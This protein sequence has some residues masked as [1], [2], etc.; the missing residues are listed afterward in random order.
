MGSLGPKGPSGEKGTAGPAGPPGNPG[1]KGQP[2]PKVSVHNYVF[3]FQDYIKVFEGS[4][5]CVFFDKGQAGLPGNRG[6]KGI[7]G[8]PVSPFFCFSSFVMHVNSNNS[9]NNK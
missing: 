7:A 4:C 1:V 3:F 6:S 8:K 9:S 5:V 2:G